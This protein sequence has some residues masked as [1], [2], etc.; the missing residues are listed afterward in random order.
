MLRWARCVSGLCS[1]VIDAPS[2]RRV[3]SRSRSST[4]WACCFTPDYPSKTGYL[5]DHAE[6]SGLLQRLMRSITESGGAIAD[7]PMPRLLGVMELTHN[8]PP[9][10]FPGYLFA[11]E[12]R[13]ALLI[14]KVAIMTVNTASVLGSGTVDSRGVSRNSLFWAD[15]SVPIATISPAE[16]IP[17]ALVRVMPE[18]GGMSRFKSCIVPLE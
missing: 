11:D 5:Q 17:S 16:S 7:M 3:H 9:Q 13:A 4:D 8:P 18:R 14:T 10:M 2:I 15:A 6:I 12:Q 1:E